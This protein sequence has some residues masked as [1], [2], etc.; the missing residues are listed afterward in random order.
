M[1]AAILNYTKNESP[2]FQTQNVVKKDWFPSILKGLVIKKRLH[3]IY[4]YRTYMRTFEQ[5]GKKH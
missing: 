1:C 2:S 3:L 4:I 5:E